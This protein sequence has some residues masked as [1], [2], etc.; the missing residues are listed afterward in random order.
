MITNKQRVVAC[1]DADSIAVVAAVTNDSIDDVIDSCHYHIR[2]WTDLA[3]A[4]TC[5]VFVS[6][7]KCF[8][9]DVYED[10]KSNRRDK[11]PIPFRKEAVDYLLETYPQDDLHSDPR[12][13]ADD[14][15]GYYATEDQDDEVRVIVS[16][17]KDLVQVPTWVMNPDKWRFPCLI[18][19]EVALKKRMEQWLCGDSADGYPGIPR[20]GE[21][22]FEKWWSETVDSYA[23]DGVQPTEH[24]L[25]MEGY[26]LYEDKGL[27]TKTA[28]EQYLCSTIKHHKLPERSKSLTLEGLGEVETTKTL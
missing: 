5:K 15:L 7:G 28:G 18:P 17:D 25:Y 2:R 16:I 21:K 11:P 19:H 6:Q 24:N 1:L 23:L 4:D 3:H 26:G 9:Y 12:L 13:E 22:G 14:R 20:F 8:R 27:T 10:Y